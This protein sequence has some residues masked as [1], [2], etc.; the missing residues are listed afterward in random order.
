M[1]TLPA[2]TH[3]TLYLAIALHLSRQDPE[4]AQQM[5]AHELADLLA[6]SQAAM[7]ATGQH[8]QVASAEDMI[9][10]VTNARKGFN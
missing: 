9:N 1:I 8:G 4:L 5:T 6:E 2:R 7:D 10:L 3:G